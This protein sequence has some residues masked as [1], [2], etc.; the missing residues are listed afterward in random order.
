MIQGKTFFCWWYSFSLPFSV[1]THQLY[2]L[3]FLINIYERPSI[4][5]LNC[6]DNRPGIEVAV[7]HCAISDKI[8]HMSQQ[9]QLLSGILSGKNVKTNFYL[10]FFCLATQAS[11]EVWKYW[12]VLKYQSVSHQL[13][14][15][16]CRPSFSF[17]G[18]VFLSWK[19]TT[20]FSSAF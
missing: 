14:N 10:G 12:I 7:G 8:L 6:F 19:L 9:N 20:Y 15:G 1:V 13:K 4:E 5:K 11:V 16:A 17:C 18:L 3:W 2:I